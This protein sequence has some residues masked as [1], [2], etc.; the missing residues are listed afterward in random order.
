MSIIIIKL[1]D[2]VNHFCVTYTADLSSVTENICFTPD[3][4]LKKAATA[5]LTKAQQ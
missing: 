5:K 4:A 1:S 2:D 3:F